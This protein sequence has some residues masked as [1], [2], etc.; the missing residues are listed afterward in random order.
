MSEFNPPAKVLHEDL[1][2]AKDSIAGK[3]FFLFVHLWSV[4]G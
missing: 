4:I 2:I 3:A 1:A